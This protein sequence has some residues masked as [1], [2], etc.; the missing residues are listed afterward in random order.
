M[1][2]AAHAVLLPATI[3]PTPAAIAVRLLKSMPPADTH[4]PS[5]RV[6]RKSVRT[7]KR[8]GGGP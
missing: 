8:V 5:L 7:R 6:T 4:G 2:A 3:A 1:G